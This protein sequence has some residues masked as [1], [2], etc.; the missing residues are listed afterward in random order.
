MNLVL[1]VLQGTEV[2][3][4]FNAVVFFGFAIV[5]DIEFIYRGFVQVGFT[6]RFVCVS[7]LVERIKFLAVKYFFL[8]L[9]F[10]FR[11]GSVLLW[12]VFV[13]A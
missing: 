5:G 11:L 8:F 10:F 3:F 2:N 4:E 7:Y 12:V 1:L 9:V 6:L 13:L